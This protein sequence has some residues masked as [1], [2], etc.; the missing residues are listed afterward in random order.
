VMDRST[1]QVTAY[2]LDGEAEES[3]RI[4]QPTLDLVI[5]APPPAGRVL[6]L[7]AQ[8]SV[9]TGETQGDTS[10]FVTTDSVLQNSTK[11]KGEVAH[12]VIKGQAFDHLPFE[13]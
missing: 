4:A 2:V 7:Q 6:H 8:G 10:E 1:G 3:V 5:E 11:I 13:L 9:L 12:V